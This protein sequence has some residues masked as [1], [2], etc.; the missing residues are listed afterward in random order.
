[1]KKLN[2]T[3]CKQLLILLISI[4]CIAVPS[5]AQ[6]FGSELL[7]TG[8]FGTT[9]DGKNGDGG[10]GMNVYP[11]PYTANP[12]IGTY[13][14]PI[15]YVY[16]RNQLTQ[17]IVNPGVV[18]GMPLGTTQTSYVW[19]FSETWY[20]NLY[21]FPI[22]HGGGNY[23][24]S[25]IEVPMAPNNG[26]YL[27]ATS[28][29]GMYQPPILGNM[30]SYPWYLVYDRYETNTAAPTNYFMVVNADPDNTKIFYK[31]Q[32]AVKPGQS[33]RM[34]ADLVRLNQG[35]AGP[36]VAF[37]I[38][39]NEANLTH[40]A[41]VYTSGAVPDNGGVWNTYDFDYVAPCGVTSVWIAFRN[42]QTNTNGNDLALDNL[43]FKELKALIRA[44]GEC[45]TNG[46][47][48]LMASVP[49][50][51]S[52]T[53]YSYEWV[54]VQSPSDVIVKTLS[55]DGSFT[56]VVDGA[57]YARVF[58]KS[59]TCWM[60]TDT[61]DIQ[62]INTG[63]FQIA[64]PQPQPDSYHANPGILLTQNVMVNS[65]DKNS[66]GTLYTS[67]PP[68]D[69]NNPM[70]SV[71]NFTTYT[72]AS[73]R[74]AELGGNIN[75]RGTPTVNTTTSV[76]YPAGSQAIIKDGNGT[77]V[78]VASIATD[79]TLNFQSVPNYDYTV[80]GA[81]TSVPLA[82][83]ILEKNGGA[84]WTRVDIDLVSLTV[85]VNAN[86]PCNPVKL[87][88]HSINFDTDQGYT[89]EEIAAQHYI[90]N[91]ITGVITSDS[92]INATSTFVPYTDGRTGGTQTIIF[93]Q[94]QSGLINFGFYKKEPD[95]DPNP[96]GDNLL[97]SFNIDMSPM[98]AEWKDVPVSQEWN[99][100]ANWYSTGG[101]PTWCTDVTI[102][103]YSTNYPTLIPNDNSCRDIVFK[104]NATVGQIQNLT[105]RAA[106]V[107]YTP[108]EFDK[109]TMLSA[110]LK[111][112][113]SADLQPDPSWS[114]SSAFDLIKS[115]MS[116]FDLKYS[117]NKDNPDGRA[118]TIF[119]SFSNPFAN[120]KEELT[121]GF[122]F[123]SDV[124]NATDGGEFQIVFSFPRFIPFGNAK[125]LETEN[126]PMSEVTYYYHYKDNGEWIT[127]YPDPS[128]DP[129]V[130]SRGTAG[131]IDSTTWNDYFLDPASGT[132]P[133]P[134]NRDSR[135]RFVYEDA[136][137]YNY[138]STDGS[139]TV[140]LDASGSTRIV[141]NPFMSHIDFVAFSNDNPNINPFYRIWDGTT[142]Y[143]YMVGSGLPD[144][145]T[146][147]GLDG[148]STGTVETA[149]QFIAPMQAFFVETVSGDDSPLTL[150]F[151]PENISTVIDTRL[152]SSSS[153]DDDILKFRLKM[154]D[155][156]N[157]A[158]LASLPKGSDHYDAK[159]DVY[160]LF[161]F[162]ES[163]PEIYTLADK[164]AIEINAVSNDGDLKI[165]PLG[166]KTNQTGSFGIHVEMP[167]N[168]SAYPY[169]FLRDA[170]NNIDYD[171][172]QSSDFVFDKTD[173]KD[174]EDRFFVILS[175]SPSGIDTLPVY[176]ENYL[177][178][179]TDNGKIS[180]SSLK[181]QIEKIELYDVSGSL[182]YNNADVNALSFS[183][184]PNVSKGIFILKTETNK[185]T[186]AKKIIL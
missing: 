22:D 78:G 65:V 56:P 96:S 62:L 133:I 162:D 114:P 177:T 71:I 146:W 48:T 57:Y 6:N 140:T 143:S 117:E 70:I 179:T 150:S 112:V 4:I 27:I 157:V 28:S 15:D 24:D 160:K 16:Y 41:P 12:A 134:P 156:E 97:M 67:I 5:N 98:T 73:E 88:F 29:G 95:A 137:R 164:V 74:N 7:H 107:D 46:Y 83:T 63:C 148:L 55:S 182:Q 170:L 186:I 2:V 18:V 68:N 130:L 64:L 60:N 58:Y 20:T 129:F 101:H 103:Q 14:Q 151:K 153:I 32:V 23:S 165:I 136:S 43:S 128:R 172:S 102:P 79:G 145:R 50:A 13:Y 100:A 110:P 144:D 49:G 111:Y 39:A 19:G 159:E 69:P 94:T 59:N 31:Q 126:I 25:R 35:A 91:T 125:I 30:P 82:Y 81:F 38:D 173:T 77:T 17:T 76:T 109:W 75:K 116:Y 11:G 119:G 181:D 36:N 89:N 8:N 174:I 53:D 124:I 99:N 127:N 118:G 37:I 44:T 3:T 184:K 66:K 86:C 33:Y 180:V 149:S 9:A 90:V 84:A 34:T 26:N 139:F 42:I 108:I 10:V 61:I 163:V 166:I 158:V 152:R 183:F 52:P 131:K 178:V 132:N 93:T 87:E 121:A 40:V 147:A 105:Y 113:Y 92:S 135:Y 85:D 155:I 72:S 80:P 45:S 122:G 51:I 185:G 141:G 120:L 1:M 47:S 175:T 176:N 171:L 161:S 54:K 167:E 21:T 168:F 138:N 104:T 106:Y 154:N 142:F 169:V 115:Y 123:A